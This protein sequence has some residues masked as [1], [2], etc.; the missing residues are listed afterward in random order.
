M[1]FKVQE[2]LN[3][4]ADG[5]YVT[6]LERRIVYWN[7]A[8]EEIT[9]WK[10]KDVVGR[11]CLDGILCH[12]DKDGHQLCGQQTCP[13]YRAMVTGMRSPQEVVVFA[14]SASG[15]RVPMR[16][17]TAPLRSSDGR[18]I[19]G[20]ETF[21]DITSEYKDLFRAQRVQAAALAHPDIVDPRVSVRERYVPHDV[22]GGDFHALIQ[23]DADRLAFWI[24]DVMGHG[25]SAAL[26]AMQLRCFWSEL[27]EKLTDPPAFVHAVN[28]RLIET[29]SGDDAF[30]TLVYGLLDL[31]EPAITL[32]SAGG[33]P[34]LL[35][36]GDGALAPK[37]DV[38]GPPLGFAIRAPFEVL[39]LRLQ[40]GDCLL[41]YT[42][43]AVE[44]P[45][46]DGTP[47]GRAGLCKLLAEL[48]YPNSGTTLEAIEKALLLKSGAIRLPDDLTLL[49]IRLTGRS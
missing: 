6:D 8:A 17:S 38:G 22:I 28:G 26:Y 14:R 29:K 3:S 49:E 21:R 24:G 46:A 32:V 33:P 27:V 45:T 16:V 23:P 40:P 43:G 7:A 30:A 39:R 37:A 31:T 9:G 12:V 44:F 41:F 25:L 18:I 19:G 35:Y 13:L 5:L 4:L 2:V 36:N 1:D 20:V 42:D 34:P 47:L 11:Q 15:R 48:G 10:A